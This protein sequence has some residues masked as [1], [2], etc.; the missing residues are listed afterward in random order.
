MSKVA[1]EIPPSEG[2]RDGTSLNVDNEIVGKIPEHSKLRPHEA[3]KVT[4]LN[5]LGE[6][7]ELYNSLLDVAQAM[8]SLVERTR[9]HSNTMAL[10][11]RSL[12]S[13]R[14]LRKQSRLQ[15][16]I[17]KRPMSGTSRSNN[18]RNTLYTLV[19]RV[20]GHVDGSISR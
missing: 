13:V 20:N 19:N 12:G 18:S 16:A 3:R 8:R 2:S 5:T 14:F 6:I 9:I 17:V 11:F 15:V 10:L 1:R 7:L 4:R